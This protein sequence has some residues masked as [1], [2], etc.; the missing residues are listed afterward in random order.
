MRALK[1]TLFALAPT[2][3]VLAALEVSLALLGAGER[4]RNVWRG[5]DPDAAYLKP[6]PEH[7]GA[8]RTQ[9]FAGHGSSDFVIPPKSEKTRVLLFGGSN[10]QGFAWKHLRQYL[11][12]GAPP[13]SPGFEVVN[14]GRSG[15]GSARVVTI[16]EQALALEPDVAVIYSG[17]NEFVEASFRMD[18][19]AAYSGW[20]AP[21]AEAASHL[22]TFNA[23]VEGFSPDPVEKEKKPEE[24]NWEYGKFLKNTYDQ[25]RE[26]MAHYQ[27]NLRR[28]LELARDAEVTVVL[29]TVAGNPLAAPFR[30]N[31]PADFPPE[32][33]EEL[34]ELVAR[35][36]ELVPPS[37]TGIV[38][39]HPSHRLHVKDWRPVNP[40][41][42]PPDF[43]M[44]RLRK[45][46]PPFD[47]RMGWW[48]APTRWSAKVEPY[49]RKLS[50][51]HRREVSAEERVAL[52]ELRG[53]VERILELCP[54]HPMAHHRLALTI[55]LLEGDG[56]RTAEH[57]RLAARYD[58]APRKASGL[59]NDLVRELVEEFPEVVLWDLETLVRQ[60][61]PNGIVGYELMQ[62]ECHFH[63]AARPVLMKELCRVLLEAT[64]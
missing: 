53:V 9:M 21:L 46:G 23:L 47:G 51:F 18:L 30:S 14:L 10:T 37:L 49:L 2:V 26:R 16:F 1:H 32:D 29:G 39:E 35:A 28:M 64:R 8:W 48:P 54:D 41:E 57:L 27:D 19:E 5:F 7:E 36:D 6:H 11:N 38:P 34:D 58:R 13:G 56:Q 24:W 52:E 15:Y 44:P 12:E 31:P 20:S 61:A 22:R 4:T 50:A 42:V 25:T 33:A 62:D 63:E 45:Y 60:S 59:S 3:L 43:Q 55:W 40:A 17:H